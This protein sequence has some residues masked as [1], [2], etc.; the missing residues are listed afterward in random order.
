MERSTGI[1]GIVL[2]AL[3]A[4]SPSLAVV[5]GIQPLSAQLAASPDHGNGYRYNGPAHKY[6]PAASELTTEAVTTT[7]HWQPN[8]V[9]QPAQ[10]LP[11]EHT[12]GSGSDSN[13]HSHSNSISDYTGPYRMEYYERAPIEQQQLNMNNFQYAAD[14]SGAA[15]AAAAGQFGQ[16]VGLS[17]GAQHDRRMESGQRGAQL[18]GQAL[19]ERYQRQ[20]FA[21]PSPSYLQMQSHSYE[22][23]PSYSMHSEWYEPQTKPQQMFQANY[24]G[25][26]QQQ[27][28]LL[29][30]QQQQQQQQLLPQQHQQQQQ[31]QQLLPQQH[32]QQ[33]QQQHFDY[34]QQLSSFHDHAHTQNA[35][36]T[37]PSREF[38]A[39]YY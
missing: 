2:T 22:L 31:Q 17:A 29:P 16:A 11:F 9:Q 14:N 4:C 18:V 1:L 8:P 38:Q 39:P 10:Q 3:L 32:Q 34:S 30:Q 6:L 33:Q 23:P 28:Q 13:S 19:P 21:Q 5:H 26:Q 24:Y 12:F 20:P 36:I 7:G 25:Q 15:A 35:F 27:Q 37:Q